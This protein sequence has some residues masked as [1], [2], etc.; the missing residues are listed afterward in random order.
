MAN[1]DGSIWTVFNGEIYNHRELRHELEAKGHHFRGRSDTEILPHLYQEYGADSVHL[2][3]GMFA[4]AIYDT[5][6]NRLLLARDRFG[7]KPL[8]YAPGHER[9][10]FASELN[11]LRLVPEIDL[12]PDPQAVYDFAAL[13]YIP[14]PETFFKGIR[15]LEPGQLLE[16]K[17]ESGNLEWKTR[18][19]HSWSLAPNPALT[20]DLAVEQAEDLIQIAVGRQMESDVPLGSLLSG[21]ID[22]SLVSSAAQTSSS[23]NLRTFNVRFP[24]VD[25]DETWAA[26]AV[27]EH[28]KSQ[29]ETLA[30]QSAEGT[31]ES[32]TSLLRHAGQPFADT[33]IFAV[34]AVCQQ[35]KQHVVVA[36]SGD[37][38]DEAFGGYDF[39]WQ[40]EW[41]ARWQNLPPWV[42][43]GAAAALQVPVQ[44]RVIPERL[45]QRF[46][47]V[48]GAD[49]TTVVE[50]LS[51]WT[52]E[53]EH[54]R[55]CRGHGL[56]PVRR[57]FEQQWDHSLPKQA[58]RV[59]GL[60]ALMTEV[61]FRLTLP[62]DYL[63]KVDIAS[64]KES[65]EIRVP[66]LD[67]DLV[68]F[69]LT[70]PHRLKVHNRTGKRVLRK[71]AARN[72]PA[73]VATK[74]KLGFRFPIDR[75]VDDSFRKRLQEAL[76][77]KTSPLPDFFHP[78]T[79]RPWVEA[80][81]AGQ[82]HP[83]LSRWGLYQRIIMLLAIQQAFTVKN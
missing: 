70:L 20:L 40:I 35:M 22:S 2:L 77:G 48:C 69:G 58:S 12:E 27:A 3:R 73:E 15:A 63:F 37:G 56:L 4:F 68:E 67:E 61:N 74:K 34:N 7:I 51:R 46:R 31:W 24:D 17:W 62:N 9:L 45:L 5:G 25:F 53:G 36:L 14:A 1:E 80:F 79:Y 19:Y 18:G 76:I 49:N 81:C 10:A 8:F 44:L 59:E 83:E 75:W 6:T 65:I 82:Q 72:L 23:G 43:R 50:T 38:G 52:R 29:H 42:W 13:F 64:M 55:L 32:I 60:S 28:I 54:R 11:A 16:A 30:I 78:E 71:V 21:G 26:L 66:M 47:E 39:Y 57:H 41:I 33:S